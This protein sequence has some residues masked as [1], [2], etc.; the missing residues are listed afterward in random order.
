MI[1]RLYP[2]VGKPGPLARP[3]L[4]GTGKLPLG[5]RGISAAQFSLCLILM[6]GLPSHP[7]GPL[8]LLPGSQLLR[9]DLQPTAPRPSEGGST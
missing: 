6:P 3:Q 1:D 5:Q 4:A 2:L 9:P 7:V 8:L